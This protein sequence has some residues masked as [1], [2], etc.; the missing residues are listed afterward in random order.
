MGPQEFTRTR[1]CPFAQGGGL[2]FL[3]GLH[4]V[5]DRGASASSW[6]STFSVPGF[7]SVIWVDKFRAEVEAKKASHDFQPR[8]ASTKVD[9]NLMLVLLLVLAS[10]V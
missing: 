5:N 9:T 4:L 1:C 8:Y 2:V 7:L 10:V 3:P 6:A